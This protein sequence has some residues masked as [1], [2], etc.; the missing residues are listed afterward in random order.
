[1]RK[2]RAGGPSGR[3]LKEDVVFVPNQRAGCNTSA[4]A[5]PWLQQNLT[6]PGSNQLKQFW[7]QSIYLPLLA[8][9][10]CKT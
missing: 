4:S 8:S 5:T 6:G 9:F 3:T 7:R 2:R 10:C 1:M